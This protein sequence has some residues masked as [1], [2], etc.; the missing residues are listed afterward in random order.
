M[1]ITVTMDAQ[2]LLKMLHVVPKE[3]I[4]IATARALNKTATSA[5]SVAVKTVAI[6]IGIA[7]KAVRP[8]VQL[9]KASRVCLD[10]VL[11][12]AKDKRLPLIKIDPRAQQ[13]ATGVTYRGSGGMRRSLPHAFIATMPSGHLGIYARKPGAARLPIR[14]LLGPSLY[15]VF[16]QPAVQNAMEQVVKT[17]W[18]VVCEQEINWELKRRSL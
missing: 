6:Q 9:Q 13:N 18:S 15:Y 12:V 10:A 4:P 2:A 3:V 1:H 16:K 14:E 7:Q 11:F 5:K 17:R 8:F